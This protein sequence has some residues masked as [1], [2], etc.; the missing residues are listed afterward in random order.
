[1]KFKTC[2]ARY[3]KKPG[4]YHAKPKWFDTYEKELAELGLSWN[5][6][7]ERPGPRYYFLASK[8]WVARSA[9]DII[10]DYLRQ[11]KES[12]K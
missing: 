12:T 3:L 11:L 8:P 10:A 1:M 6:E 9:H 2:L 5:S 7:Q 4:E